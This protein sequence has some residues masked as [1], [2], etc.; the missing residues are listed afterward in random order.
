MNAINSCPFPTAWTPQQIA[1][2]MKPR[3]VE[4][5][6]LLANIDAGG[7]ANRS[8][9]RALHAGYLP[10]PALAARFRMHG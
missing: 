10:Q 9:T 4:L 6:A 3:L 1:G 5:D 2:A 8:R 7:A